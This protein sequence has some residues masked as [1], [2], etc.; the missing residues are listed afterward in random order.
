LIYDFLLRFVGGQPKKL[1]EIIKKATKERYGSMEKIIQLT[2]G[3]GP[4][5]CTLAVS[6]ALKELLKEAVEANLAC[7]V[8]NRVQGMQNGTLVSA[9]VLVKG[10]CAGEFC[11]TWDGVLQWICKS[12]FRK[13]H[14]RKNWFI[15]I[16]VFDHL[17]E[18]KI[19][20]RDIEYKTMKATGAGGQHVNKTQSA[21]RA[22]HKPSGITI[23]VMDSRSQHENRKLAA[24]R[25]EEKISIWQSMELVK[26]ANE[27][28]LKHQDLERG[29]P[30]RI[31]MGKD[32]NR[33][34]M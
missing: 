4:A 3:K 24:R 19:N 7:D 14:P 22:T 23:T 29:N 34:T 17:Q 18:S 9:M 15:A 31:Y 13:F 11:R 25:L 1:I 28:W 8:M 26:Q 27:Q 2:A 20:E 6:F 33:L 12:P 16:H 10:K 30:K 5:E 21:V 32:F